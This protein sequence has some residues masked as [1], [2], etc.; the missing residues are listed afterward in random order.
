MAEAEE[1]VS[2][3]ARYATSYARDLWQRHRER[4]GTPEI[5][6][7][8]DVAA[9]LDLLLTT[10]FGHVHTIRVAQQPA[11]PTLLTWVFGRRRG[12]MRQQAI[13][14]TDGQTIWLPAN[15]G[16]LDPMLARQRYRTMA[17]QQAVRAQRGSTALW[18][19]IE[20]SLTGDIYLLLEAQA[21][22]T[23]LTAMLPGMAAPI[24]ELRAAALSARPPLSAFPAVARELERFVRNLM[25]DQDRGPVSESPDDAMR[26]AE[27]IAA[28]L[29]P[30]DTSRRGA[31]AMRVLKD[32]WTGDLV[33][34]NPAV[35]TQTIRTEHDDDA[36]GDRPRSIYLER[37]PDVRD[38]DDDEDENRKDPGPWMIQADEPHQ[39]AED[40]MGV[41]RPTDRDDGSDA[42]QLGEMLSELHE[43]RL[44]TSPGRPKEVLL[45]DDPPHTAAHHHLPDREQDEQAIRYPEWNYRTG[46][47]RERGAT[48][49]TLPPEPGS[50]SW[51]NRTLEEHRSMLELIRHR[52]EMLQA[53]RIVRRR[54]LDGDEIDFDTCVNAFADLKAGTHMPEGLYQRCRLAERNLAIMLLIDV[55][56]STDGWVSSTRRIIDVE[57]EALLLVCI[58]L[59]EMAE[60][61]AVMAFSGRGP[62]GVTVRHIKDF[63]EPY[64]NDIALRISSLE[65][66]R[67]TRAGAA[68][69]HATAMLMQQAASHRL[70][71]LLSDGKPN[72]IDEY[73]GRYGAE[74]M[75]QAVN[76]ARLQGLSPF[77]LTIDRQAA[78]YLPRIFGANQYAMLSRPELLPT[79]L[80]DWMRRLLSARQ[81]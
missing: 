22:D 6:V 78:A 70:L 3:V 2:D 34:P 74:D 72:D 57:R 56:G 49:R 28:R 54:Q 16:T 1:V 38:A 21:A 11:P 77:C 35:A 62:Q 42:G 51:V 17:L 67:Y 53:R 66:E 80:L 5:L 81:G 37:R 12:P 31:I 8:S 10:V 64:S 69:R 59:K 65:P 50:Q 52:F 30:P 76:E 41:Q 55:S 33:V 39:K 18:P 7:L 68:I 9:R 58:A 47:Y 79:V 44:V 73:E 24:R 20:K 15:L 40:P 19:G 14:A 13:P 43:A 36:D 23:T 46:H 32:L 45:S 48:V 71:L 75:R 25:D 27:S 60:P 63:D 61:F 26:L 4:A 29:V